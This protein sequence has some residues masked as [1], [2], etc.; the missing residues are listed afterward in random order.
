[1][2]LAE[3]DPAAA[4]RWAE[5][6]PA[7]ELRNNRTKKVLERWL[8]LNEKAARAWIENSSLSDGQK[9][10]LIRAPKP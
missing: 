7:G 6:L 8:D 1:M 9:K 5:M 2:A 3:T 10:D 4:V